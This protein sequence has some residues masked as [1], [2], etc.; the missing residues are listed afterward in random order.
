MSSFLALHVISS[1]GLGKVLF[2]V[3]ITKKK[4]KNEK[5]GDRLLGGFTLSNATK[6]V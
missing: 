1:S 4:K 2:Q 3:H 6:S 5:N